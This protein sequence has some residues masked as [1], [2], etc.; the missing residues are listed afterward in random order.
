MDHE[1]SRQDQWAGDDRRS[2][3]RVLTDLD[4]RAI[5]DELEQRA[6]QRFQL[7]IGRGV[8]ALAWKA[9]LYLTIW[10]A[11]YGTAG[12]FKKFLP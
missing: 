9:C 12:G 3:R 5:V 10:V 7:N 1:R 4:V 11:A 8:V 6:S 2:P